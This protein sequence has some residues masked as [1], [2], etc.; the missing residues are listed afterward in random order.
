MS[1]RVD[2]A[3]RAVVELALRE[4]GQ[5]TVPAGEIASDTGVPA[6]IL[7]AILTDLNKAGLITSKR[8][9]DG[10]QHLARG[11]AHITVDQ[12]LR[13]VE[14][15][16]PPATITGSGQRARIERCLAEL[17]AEMDRAI[18]S[19]TE[20]VTLEDLR[21]RAQAHGALDFTI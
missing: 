4:P 20:H 1:R 9:P 5:Q 6:K 16:A 18:A 7:G 17:F 8:G 11:P 19:V 15:P 14:S 3:L 10:G 21:R 12:I 13:A 2:H